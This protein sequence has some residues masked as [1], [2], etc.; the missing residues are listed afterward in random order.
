ML[1]LIE[2]FFSIHVF[3]IAKVCDWLI[4]DLLFTLFSSHYLDRK[5]IVY[6]FSF[7]SDEYS[8]CTCISS[9]VALYTFVRSIFMCIKHEYLE[10]PDSNRCNQI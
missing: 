1:G 5:Y 9:L 7:G 3:G 4:A 2:K 10:G 8:T 6:Q